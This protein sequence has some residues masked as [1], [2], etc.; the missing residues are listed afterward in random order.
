MMNWQQLL[1]TQRFSLN[2][3]NQICKTQTSSTEEG[4]E[5]LRSDFLIDYDRVVFSS[6]FRRLGRKTQV[7]PLAQHDHTHN[8]LT[9]SVEVASVGRSLG[10]RVGVMMQKAGLLPQQNTP[11]DIGQVVQVACL[12]HDLG[13]P[14][15]GHTGE[16]ALK[17]WFFQPENQRYLENL[18]STQKM[19]IQ[20]Y[21][22]NAHSLRIVSNLEM[23]HNQGGMRLSAASIGTLLKYPWTSSRA[24]EYKNKF[25]IYQ[26]ELPFIQAIAEELGLPQKAENYWARHP[27]SYLME[28]AD[29]ICYAILD[30][31]DAVEIGLIEDFELEKILAPI[32]ATERSTE[33]PT[34]RQRCAI[35]RGVAIG[36]CIE[37]VVQQFINHQ[38][39]LL[40]GNLPKKDLISLCN[41]EVKET[42]EAAKHLASYRI[43]RHRSKLVTEIAAF[44][45]LGTIL[46]LL[47]PAVFHKIQ[48][49]P[50]STQHQLALELLK[51][52]PIQANDTLYLAYMKVLDF[53]GTMTDNA[54]AKLAR[55]ISGVGI[56]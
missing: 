16:S 22:G 43:Y 1:S 19:D 6:A 32:G 48:Q 29:D 25:N 34:I 39:D 9:H 44:P 56:L 37:E 20:S 26:T 38:H 45:C 46:N 7:H 47:I 54:A 10:N 5:T 12:A 23:Y 2:K 30:L 4:K 53:V 15:F 36:K 8:R 3:S 51:E 31:E 14:P 28:A 11:F 33:A 17:E 35:L 41:A 27:L 13:N 55:E 18:S 50:L 52:S 21:E 40:I 42:L 24:H 49:S